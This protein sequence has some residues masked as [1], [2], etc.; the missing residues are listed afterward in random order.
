MLLQHHGHGY[1]VPHHG[2]KLHVVPCTAHHYQSCMQ[3][4]A[5][6]Q[7][8]SI[9]GRKVLLTHLQ[10]S[11]EFERDAYGAPCIILMGYRHTKHNEHAVTHGGMELPPIRTHHVVREVVKLLHHAVQSI[12]IETCSI[13][14]RA[15]YRAAEYRDQFAL[16]TEPSLIRKNHCTLRRP[17]SHSR[18][19]NRGWRRGNDERLSTGGTERGWQEDI[20]STVGAGLAQAHATRSTEGG[21][22]LID[23]L[24]G[25]A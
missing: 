6:C 3:A 21:V 16:S 22:L 5:A 8:S 25:R 24:A 14:R 11:T 18:C 19:G 9:H 15:D 2:G 23:M 20:L 13:C 1:D 7:G 17:G 4:Y 12:E 10:T